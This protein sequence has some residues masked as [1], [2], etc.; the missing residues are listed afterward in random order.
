MIREAW[1]GALVLSAKGWEYVGVG[2]WAP[3]ARDWCW[4]GMHRH[5]M[6]GLG[7]RGPGCFCWGRTGVRFGLV[8]I[9]V[10]TGSTGR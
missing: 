8:C 9:D 2:A 4:F 3:R 1:V 10:D 6:L 5:G 7:A